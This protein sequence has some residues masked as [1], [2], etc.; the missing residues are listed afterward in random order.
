M[1]NPSGTA[2]AGAGSFVRH[3]W[4][5]VIVVAGVLAVANLA[6]LLASVQDSSDPDDESLPSSI[7]SVSPAPGTQADRRTS[8]SVDLRDGL[9]GVLVID[10]LRLPEDQLDYNAPQSI[11]TFR[12][13]SDAEFSDFEPGE[14]AVQVLYWK[15]G[16]EEPPDPSSYGWTFRA[17]A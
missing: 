11:I 1:A 14:H 12:P 2:P 6:V 7:E 17:T 4:R 8:V 10:R 9:T 15:Q 16:E 5:I 13:G 3:P